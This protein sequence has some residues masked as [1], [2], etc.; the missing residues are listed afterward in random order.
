MLYFNEKSA[1]LRNQK[2]ALQWAQVLRFR[3]DLTGEGLWW[4]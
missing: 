2:E 4:P 3:E 1:S